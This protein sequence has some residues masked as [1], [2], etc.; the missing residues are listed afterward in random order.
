MV[1]ININ[2]NLRFVKK[3]DKKITAENNSSR[4]YN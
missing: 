3:K 1:K 2:N 4:F